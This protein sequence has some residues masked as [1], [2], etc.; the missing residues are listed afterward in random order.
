MRVLRI[1]L[2]V[3]ALMPGVASACQIDNKASLFVGGVQAIL[4]TAAPTNTALWAPFTI[5]KAFASGAAVSMHELR[6]DLAKTL[7]PGTLAAPYRWA[8]GDG[9]AALGHVVSH[10]YDH[11][12]QYR[13]VVSGYNAATRSWFAF[14]QAVL[15][16]VPPGQVLQ[17]N[18][19]YYALRALDV[20]VSSLMWGIDA[21]LILLVLYV[22]VGRR[23]GRRSRPGQT[24]IQ[25]DRAG[26]EEG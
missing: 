26:A 19:G 17:A 6:S 20:A 8:F 10:R 9:G 18:L 15:R 7:S 1:A 21:L 14:D 24:E 25:R 23:R 22:V 16:I 5:E 2:V 3:L 12:G 11:P 4:N 13:L